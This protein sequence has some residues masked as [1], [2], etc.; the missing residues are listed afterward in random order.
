M[1]NEKHDA[2]G[3]PAIVEERADIGVADEKPQTTD[4][5]NGSSSPSEAERSKSDTA[6]KRSIWRRAYDILTWTPPS[7]R[8]NPDKPPKFSMGLNVL[9]GFAGAFTV[10][11]LYYSHPILNVLA[12]DFGVPYEKVSEIPTLAQ[13]GYA[14]G[15][16]FLCPLGDIVE[17][18]PFVLSLVFFT[19]TMS[20]GLATTKSIAVFSAIQFIT[21]VTTVTP[22]LML[23]LVGDLAPPKRRAAALSIV[24]SGLML[25]ILL[26]RLLSGIMTQYTSWRNVYWLSV[27][28]QYAIFVCLW[29]YMPDYPSTNKGGMNYFKMLWSIL[30]MLTKHPVLVQAC[31]ISFFT[32]ATFTNFWTVLTFL[33]AGAPYNY[34]PVTI[35]LFALVGIGSMFCGPLWARYVIDRFVPLFSVILGLGW[36][37]LGIAL[38]TYTGTFTVAGPILQAFFGDFGMQTSQIANRSAIFAVEPKGRNRVNTAFMVSTFCGQLVGT[39]VGSHLFSKGGWIASGSYSM[40]SIGVALLL[41]LVRGPWEDGWVGWHGGWSIKK[42]SRESSDGKAAV[43]QRTGLHRPNTNEQS[44]QVVTGD[45]VDVEK[46]ERHHDQHQH[47]HGHDNQEAV[48]ATDAEKSL[49]MRAAEDDS[50]VGDVGSEKSKTDDIMPALAQETQA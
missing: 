26:A 50:S 11:N 22:Q 37:L 47:H 19:A 2:N 40:G 6:S 10:A 33:L 39:S 35:G 13:A 38:G 25:G 46:G 45:D 18:R 34:D 30:V 14:A 23:P 12:D 5:Q 9:F 7:M 44:A 41:T 49:E 21:A 31:L 15:L 4:S 17:R 42:K 16:L 28:L 1:E 29:F 27:A 36:A 3:V 24:V 48:N 32:A 8:W 20:I 43:E